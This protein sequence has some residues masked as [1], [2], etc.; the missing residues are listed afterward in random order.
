MKF[1]I[2]FSLMF[3]L[4]ISGTEAMLMGAEIGSSLGEKIDAQYVPSTGNI[5]KFET[6]YVSGSQRTIDKFTVFKT[7]YD[8]FETS[9]ETLNNNLKKIL[10]RNIHDYPF[11]FGSP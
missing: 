2:F 8:I 10:I 1:H 11:I 3:S 6:S 4:F 5:S 9:D 7:L